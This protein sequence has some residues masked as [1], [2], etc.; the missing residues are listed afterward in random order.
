MKLKNTSA[1]N[2][3]LN[4]WSIEVKGKKQILNVAL[5]PGQTKTI[6]INGQVKLTNTGATINLIDKQQ[7]IVDSVTYKKSNVKTGVPVEF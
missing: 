2:I 3:D 5:S 1:A 6:N 4:G 7:H